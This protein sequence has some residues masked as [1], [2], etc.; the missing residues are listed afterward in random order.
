MDDFGIARVATVYGENY[1]VTNGE[2]EFI[3]EIT[4][5]IM[6]S[7][8]SP[9]DYP[10]VGD[11]CYVQQFDGNSLAIIHEIFERKSILKRKRAGKSV[12]FQSIAA[13]IDYA[14]IVQSLDA[15]YNIRRF[16]RYLVMARE[17][18]IEPILLLSKSD[19]LSEA[20]I[21]EKK[22]EIL[23]TNPKINV[24]AFSNKAETNLDAVKNLLL[25]GKT[26]CLIGSSGVG[27]TSLLNKLLG[28]DRFATRE[29]KQKDSKGKHTTT[30]RHLLKLKSGAMIIDTP[31]M[32]ELGNIAVE[33]AIAES[34]DD[35]TE[36]ETSCKF[37]NCSH[38]QE[39]GC[40][41]LSALADDVF[42]Q[43]RY[44]NYLK[45]L[46]ESQHN[47]TSYAEKRKKSKGLGKLY[48]SIQ[49]SN[50]KKY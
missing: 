21:E 28:E 26:F 17:G 42:S 39:K 49:K 46:K 19:L 31:G 20:E 25:P 40:A 2:R 27:K 3:A 12:E 9:L 6:F 47:K 35:I 16:E 11:W 10:T 24:V 15:D 22:A 37:S 1:S 30:N 34:F 7:A 44:E 32:R 50:R 33:A 4:G 5:K 38:T 43:E 45:I 36:L 23:E 8:E 13:N 18:R 41:I 29:I 14:L 48:R